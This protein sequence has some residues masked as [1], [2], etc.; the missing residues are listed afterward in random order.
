MKVLKRLSVSLLL[1]GCATSD[2]K[3]ASTEVYAPAPE[4]IY[5]DG[6]QYF[7]MGLMRKMKKPFDEAGISRT[8][9]SDLAN[10]MWLA[11]SAHMTPD[12]QQQFDRFAQGRAPMSRAVIH[13]V[14]DRAGFTENV[15]K[16]DFSLLGPYCPDKIPEF[17]SIV[18]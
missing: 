14:Y 1:A 17:A 4:G 16:W 2:Q 8:I 18:R 10:C 5:R 15:K 12:E 7:Y 9:R 3:A 13:E 11:F 6:E